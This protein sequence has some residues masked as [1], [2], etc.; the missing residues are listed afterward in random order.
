MAFFWGQ[1]NATDSGTLQRDARGLW[2]Y[3]HFNFTAKKGDWSQ[4][5]NWNKVP[6][7]PLP[8]VNVMSGTSLTISKPVDFPVALLAIGYGKT[9]GPTY[10]YVQPG[11][12]LDLGGLWMPNGI[13]PDSHA[14]LRMEGGELTVGNLKD[15]SN[16]VLVGGGATTSGTARFLL[17]GGKL[18]IRSGLR[19]SSL[20][21]NTN[22]G[23]FSIQGTAPSMSIQG[24]S[25]QAFRINPKGT[26]EFI[27]DEKG[28][29]TIDA[30]KMPLFFAPNTTIRVD[31]T[32]YKGPTK[33]L[34][35]LKASAITQSASPK[36]DITG[37]AKGYTPTLTIDKK[38]IVLKIEK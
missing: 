15:H 30:E 6:E 13:V 4:A 5:R 16:L 28:V 23:T 38:R 26:L 29:S 17:S 2:K 22:T 31:G 12:K 7:A 14:E 8:R 20:L 32:A 34:V 3:A 9:A 21:D 18:D 24:D 35:L 25:Y 36:I 19:V 33:T 1:L 27:L 11:A 37:F 10:V